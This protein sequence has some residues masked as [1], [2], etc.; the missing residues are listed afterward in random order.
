MNRKYTLEEYMDKIN[1]AK[2]KIKDLAISSDFIV[3]FPGETEDDFKKTLEAV[4]MVRYETIFGFKYSPRPGTGASILN[5][6]VSEVE[7][8]ARLKQ[9]LDL[10]NAITTE[11]LKKQVGEIHE[12][13]VEGLSKK[14]GSVFSGRNRK[15]RVVNFISSKKLNMGDIVHV[16]ITQAKKNSLFGEV[17]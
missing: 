11:L 3:G 13:M 15:N 17:I 9:L 4:E 7:K 1:L 10:Q 12:V 14:D 2:E 6:T 16:K 8:S 5:E